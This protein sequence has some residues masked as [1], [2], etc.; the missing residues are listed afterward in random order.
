MAEPR[1]G[2]FLNGSSGLDKGGL[3]DDCGG[4]AVTRFRYHWTEQGHDIAMPLA[5]LL[6][7]ALLLVACG[8]TRAGVRTGADTLTLD[9]SRSVMTRGADTLHPL[10]LDRRALAASRVGADLDL[11]STG[12]APVRARVLRVERRA[13]GRLAWIGRVDTAFGPQPA[14][15]VMGDDAAFG[16]IPQYVGPPLRIA[17]MAGS[18]W[19]VEGAGTE[20]PMP[21]IRDDFRIPPAGPMRAAKATSAAMPAVATAE[22][23]VVDV[24][25]LYTKSMVTQFGSESAVLTRVAYLETISNQAFVDSNANLRIHVVG[26]QSIDYNVNN[27]NG[28]ALDDITTGVLPVK[29]EIDELRASYGA[30]LVSLLRAF[31]ANTQTSAGVAWINGYHGAGFAASHGFSVVSDCAP[32]SGYYCSGLTFTHELGHNLGSHHDTET[33]AGDYG[34]YPYSRGF[35]LSQAPANFYTIMAYRSGTQSPLAR[36]SNPAISTCQDQPCGVVDQADNARSLGNTAGAVAAFRSGPVM[37]NLRVSDVALKEGDAGTKLATFSVVL[38]PASAS[39]VSFDV[40]TADASAS[41]GSDYVALALAGQTLAPGVTSKTFSVVVN[42]DTSTE[43]NETFQLLLSN[44]SG[45]VV[46]G[47]A[48]IGTLLDDDSGPALSIADVSLSEAVMDGHFTVTLSA[49]APTPI[50]FRYVVSDGSARMGDDYSPTYVF[51]TVTVPAGQTSVPIPFTIS[52]DNVVEPDE[53]FFVDLEDL[54][55]ARMG[56]GHAVGTILNDD[57]RYIRVDNQFVWNEG[58]A[59]YTTTQVTV[60][61]SQAS[62]SAVG[63]DLKTADMSATAGDDY[64]ALD[65]AGLSFSPG[66]TARTFPISIRGDTVA[67]TDETFSVTASNP[68]GALI[69]TTGFVVIVN[70]DFVTVPV[71]SGLSVSDARFNEI[72]S[73]ETFATFTVTLDKPYDVPVSFDMVTESGTAQSGVDFVPANEL[74]WV[75]QPGWM[76]ATFSV[77]VKG[78]LMVEP[79]ETFT[80][81][82]RNVVGAPV[83]KGIGLATIV[84]DDEALLSI[85]DAQVS[86]GGGD[87]STATFALTLSAPMSTPVSFDLATS[88]GTAATGTDFVARTQLAKTIDPGRTRAVFEVAV[89]GDSLAEATEKFTVTLSNVS[90]ASLARGVATGTIVDDDANLA[91]IATIQG[92]GSASPLAGQDVST[93]GIVTALADPGFFLQSA[94][95]EADADAR[96]SEGLF[97][98]QSAATARVGQRL[99]VQGRVEEARSGAIDGAATLTGIIAAA[100]TLLAPDQPLPLPVALDAPAL[101]GLAPLG[102]ERVEGMRVSAPALRVV[103]PVGGEVD[104]ARFSARGDGRFHVVDAGLGRPWFDGERAR[105]P[106]PLLV[107]SD[108]QPGAARLAADAGDRLTGLVGV[109][110]QDDGVYRLLPDPGAGLGLAAAISPRPVA[111]AGRDEATVGFINLRRFSDERAQGPGARTEASAYALRLGKTAN[112][113]CA[114]AG[115]PDVLAVADVEGR[116]ALADLAVALNERDGNLLFPAS[117]AGNPGYRAL[118]VPAAA[119]RGRNLGFLVRASETGAGPP[120]VQV[121]SVATHPAGERFGHPDRSQQALHESPPL[122]LRL[123]IGRGGGAPLELTA[124]AV[125][126]SDAGGRADVPGPHGWASE[127]GYRRARRDAQL[128]SIDRL[129]EQRHRRDP[130]EKLLLVGDFG[131]SAPGDASHR[132]AD[133]VATLHDLATSLPAGERYTVVREGRAIA[134]DHLLASPALMAAAPGA[135]AEIAR[136]NADAGEVHLGDP[137]VPLRVSDHDPIIGFFPLR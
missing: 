5:R 77:M 43:P 86:E 136:V 82:L 62:E 99:R 135:R 133:G 81:N 14:V 11:P 107:H 55:D 105:G 132:S 18:A 108:G 57:S 124:I 92:A 50:S 85:A 76:S 4:A 54:V 100:T 102:L 79:N 37:P 33:A 19:L 70:D 64:I 110:G 32:G 23:P 120:P 97:V 63:F 89:R 94:D 121:L 20:P 10:R 109:L 9:R 98:F 122:L 24:L 36:F 137:A 42:G 25:V 112:V 96:T 13:D 73:G 111:I 3:T 65:L 93:E 31:D 80:L 7:A 61:L 21:R 129:V 72:D 87:G 101:S 131:T 116:Q 118:M 38:T 27:D 60:R 115:S 58:N 39:T 45:A 68:V 40:A 74:G 1:P 106:A 117:C 119:A 69:D 53:T 84:N 28:V 34:A 16:T 51:R 48:G 78:D 26:V 114:Y 95:A 123:R 22:L 56:D 128:H 67:E 130:A 125:H 6:L 134:A 59:G 103:G 44:A 46:V 47:G 52:R 29:T 126:L 12:T 88:G 104:D 49:A 66:Q 41:A 30:D 113:I 71:P 75:L 35:R 2:R 83:V 90:G 17:S 91:P 8:S 127:A 15:I